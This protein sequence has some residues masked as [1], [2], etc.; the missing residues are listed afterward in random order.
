MNLEDKIENYLSEMKVKNEKSMVK[1]ISREDYDKLGSFERKLIQSFGN[2]LELMTPDGQLDYDMFLKIFINLFDTKTDLERQYIR[3]LFFPEKIRSATFLNLFPT[4]VY[5]FKQ[6]FSFQISPNSQGNFLIQLVT[7]YMV[8][9]GFNSGNASD[10]YVL[11]DVTL[12]GYTKSTATPN[13]I[14]ESTVPAGLFQAFI[15]T[16]C[17]LTVTFIGRVDV[18]SGYLGGGYN[19]SNVDSTLIDYDMSIFNY[20]DNMPGSVHSSIFDGINIIYFPQDSSFSTFKKPNTSSLLNF[21]PMTHRMNVYGRSLPANNLSQYSIKVDVTKVYATIPKQGYE[22][23]LPVSLDTNE[24][25][26]ESKNNTHEF[27]HMNDLS[28]FNSEQEKYIEKLLDL[29]KIEAKSITDEIHKG[30]IDKK[31]AKEYLINKVK[32]Y[33]RVP[34]ILNLKK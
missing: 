8:E 29:P 11:N 5:T 18:S 22:E 4:P 33:D 17:K 15:L 32:Q 12:D 19:L 7:P 16:A 27:I 25:S 31:L 21:C 14:Q 13:Y 9:R 2:M 6:T 20:I 3:G 30:K 28:I 10:I 26:Q 24:L 1:Y 23:A 34:I